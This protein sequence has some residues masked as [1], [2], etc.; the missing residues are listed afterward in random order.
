[1]IFNHTLDN[2][3]R[4]IGQKL[5]S[6]NSI[7]VG[8]WVG[9]GSVKEV[10]GEEGLS[11]FIEHML[12]KGTQKRSAIQIATQ[13]DDI[14]AQINAFT[15]KESTCYYIKATKEHLEKSVEM[16]SDMIINSA[17]D[18]KEMEKE[19]GVVIEEIAMVEDT[20][21]DLV[22]EIMGKEFYKNHPLGQPILGTKESVSSFS[23]KDIFNYIKKH[24]VASNML[25]SI[26]GNFE[27]SQIIDLVNKYFDLPKVDYDVPY[28]RV[29]TYGKKSLV[30]AQK[31]IEQVHTCLVMPGL[32][33]Q[34][35]SYY[36]LVVVNNAFGGN[37]SSRLFQKIR[38]D[39]GLA[40]SVYSFTS[41]YKDSGI[42]GFYAGTNANRAYEVVEIIINEIK[43]LKKH[44]LKA[45]EL[46]R[47]KNQLKGSYILGNENTGSRMVS[48]GKSML[49]N[50]KIRTEEEVINL[51]DKVD[52]N[53][54][55]NVIEQI[56][57]FESL[58][59][60]FVGKINELKNTDIDKLW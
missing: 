58:Y 54:V 48:I 14:G 50:G 11:H 53:A 49:L 34:D 35:D 25:V 12:F 5:P 36:P 27:E 55:N 40:Y 15:S 24:Y 9:T 2:G 57:A 56:F 17:F 39:K 31:D 16:L 13:M 19:K 22:M 7:S 52:K 28:P 46:E 51:I 32:S 23:Q 47:S 30:Y 59:G 38:E 1:M 42:I 4:I 20:P 6:F 41:S 3:M 37:M 8:V 33:P 43:E 26:A 29:P 18:P 60:S 45:D 21:E 10:Q 44:G